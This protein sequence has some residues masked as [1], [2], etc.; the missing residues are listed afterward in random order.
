MNESEH[1]ADLADKIAGR[2][3]YINANPDAP[4]VVALKDRLAILVD[5]TV[6]ADLPAEDFRLAFATNV[7]AKMASNTREP[8]TLPPLTTT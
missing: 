6:F 1:L 3:D 5:R 2:A 8:A 4:A 7:A